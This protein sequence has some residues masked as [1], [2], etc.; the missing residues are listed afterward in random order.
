M[1]DYQEHYLISE[2]LEKDPKILPSPPIHDFDPRKVYA[3]ALDR[4]AQPINGE[5]P[6]SARNPL[7]AEG[8][9]LGQVVYINELL[10]HEMRLVP[11][12]TWLQMFRMLGLQRALA[13]YPIIRLVFRRAS[14]TV[15]SNTVVDVPMGTEIVNFRDPTL[16]AITTR[17]LEIGVSD[18]GEIFGY[19]NARLNRK[20]RINPNVS[21]N[22]FNIIPRFLSNI[23]NVQGD[24]VLYE[25]REAENLSQ[26]MLRARQQLQRN[27]RLV[28]PRDFYRTLID[29]FGAQAA[30]II[31]FRK[32]GAPHGHYNDVLTCCV[33]PLGIADVARET[34]QARSPI[35]MV[36][37][38]ESA[39]IIPIDGIITAKIIP[40]LTEVQ[41]RDIAAKAL[42]KHINPPNGKWGD[43]DLK[44]SIRTALEMQQN[45]IYAVPEMNLFHVETRQPLEEMQIEPWHLFEIRQSIQ[46]EWLRS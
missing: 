46:F 14:Y 24:T 1:A 3:A 26:A 38:V 32:K 17:P 8:Q 23:E 31:P 37:E 35:D 45:S 12:V 10:A 18:R 6:F 39:E 15:N 43:K 2:L 11:D 20:G 30:K 34:V 33:Y 25:G 22:D 29:D 27:R 28:V 7:S 44:G 5:Q 41:A 36:V 4:L 40:S 19:V 9:L 21:P 13:E 42:V 16:S